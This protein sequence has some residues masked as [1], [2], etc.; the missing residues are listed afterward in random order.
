VKLYTDGMTNT[1]VIFRQDLPREISCPLDWKNNL[2][3]VARSRL[4][5]RNGC[6]LVLR[7][8]SGGYLPRLPIAHMC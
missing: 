1:G 4:G 2:Y 3:G 6:S 5:S 8:L 7:T